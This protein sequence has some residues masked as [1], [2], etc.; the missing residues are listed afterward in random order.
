[1]RAKDHVLAVEVARRRVEELVDRPPA[2]CRS[3]YTSR[4]TQHT[5]FAN[6]CIMEPGKDMA[7]P[8]KPFELVERFVQSVRQL[9]DTVPAPQ[10]LVWRI[11]PE[12]AR[13][14]N[15]QTGLW[16]MYARLCFETD[17]E[18]AIPETSAQ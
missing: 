4:L 6:G 14:P 16:K 11:E 3:A 10:L 18:R 9:R 17:T 2:Y 12:I 1:M 8:A 5:E 15:D 7:T 13:D